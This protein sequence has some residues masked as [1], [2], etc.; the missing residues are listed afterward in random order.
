MVHQIEKHV[1]Y[2]LFDLLY[3]GY[4]YLF[5]LSGYSYIYLEIWC[6]NDADP[7]KANSDEFYPEYALYLCEK[8]YRLYGKM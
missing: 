5:F 7:H 3:A 2:F 6:G 1:H 8:W 4:V